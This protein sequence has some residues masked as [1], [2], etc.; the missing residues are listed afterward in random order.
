MSRL[1]T[2]ETALSRS[3]LAAAAEVG[4]RFER[5]FRRIRNLVRGLVLRGPL[6]AWWTA[7]RARQWERAYRAELAR[8]HSNPVPVGPA[9][10]FSAKTSLRT[11]AFIADGMWEERDLVPEM[12]KIAE[13][14]F[15]DL[16]PALKVRPRDQAPC[17]AVEAKLRAFA[18]EQNLLSPDL[19]LFY[20]RPALL[21]EAAFHVL[22]QR[23][24][25]PL[26]G[27][28]LD[29][30]FE[31]FHYDVFSGGLDNYQKWA[32]YFDLNLTSCLPAGDWYR[33]LSLPCLYVPQ[34]VHIPEGLAPPSS[35]DF[36]Y[37]FSFVGSQKP[38]RK[39]IV[40]QILEA[41]IPLELFGGG[42]PKSQWVQEVREV[43]RTTQINLG[44]GFPTPS[45]TLT[46]LKNRDFECP[47][48]GACYL[49]T[50]NW[51]LP[52]YYELGKEILCYRTFE[53]LLEMYYY[54]AA[55]PENCLRI[56]QAAWRRCVNEHTWE[57][58]FRGV[59]AQCG[60]Q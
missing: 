26:F 4:D 27:M 57:K 52:Q 24:H 55:R 1:L 56:A 30:K 13:V 15:L 5:I 19:I 49:T 42:W 38:E 20:A 40:E 31:F 54:Y 41:G 51:E 12:R 59:F 9:P 18:Q 58:R 36:R 47:G 35:A 53:E 34:G 29:D 48:A 25:C 44:I 33:Q 43:F 32:K 2:N 39:R 22:R 60:F 50:Y 7:R 28:N 16:G 3:Q 45:T 11:I 17:E 23:W 8:I 10:A 46:N 21:S 37:R 14:V 6:L